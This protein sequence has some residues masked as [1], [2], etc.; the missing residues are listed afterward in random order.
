[1]ASGIN[2]NSDDQSEM[3]ASPDRPRGPLPVV[4][5]S[6]GLW[7]MWQDDIDAEVISS[8]KNLIHLK[9]NQSGPFAAWNLLC[10]YGPPK[11][12]DKAQ[13]W[14]SLSVYS[15]HV[16]GPKCFIGDFN[17]IS[18]VRE[19]YGGDQSLNAAISQ[20][21]KFI[22]ENHLL[23][24]GFSGPAYTWCNGRQYQSLIRERLDRVIATP[25]WC[26]MFEH[27]GVLHLSR[28]SS[29]HSLILLNTCRTVA[30][31]PPS[32]RFEAYWVT[33]PDFLKMVLES[34]NLNL[35]DDLISKLAS[36]GNFLKS[37]SRDKIGCIKNIIRNLKKKLL[38][39]QSLSPTAVIIRQE[40]IFQLN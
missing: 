4:G 17:A 38:K 12:T 30:R 27:S 2:E 21:N 10:I 3:A 16:L 13:F 26:L 28:I 37:W 20:F 29:D 35:Y 39:L 23:D 32:Y 5:H 14:R 1:M 7:L 40:K 34:W 19:K 8:S 9:I 18:S 31:R 25:D 6:G 22:H 36:L 11:R 15:Q 24:L 33:H